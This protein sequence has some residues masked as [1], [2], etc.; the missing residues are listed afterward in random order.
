[1]RHSLGSFGARGTLSAKRPPQ[2]SCSSPLH[3]PIS[4][5][6]AALTPNAMAFAARAAHAF[7]VSGRNWRT[8][9]LYTRTYVECQLFRRVARKKADRPSSGPERSC[10]RHGWQVGC[11]AE[12]L[13]QGGD[14]VLSLW[15]R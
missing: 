15:G 10:P 2:I 1:M 11:N 12:I 6:V 8:T 4:A 13:S 7:V 14:Q 3:A 9:T 5:L